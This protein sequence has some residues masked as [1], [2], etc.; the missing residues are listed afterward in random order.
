MAAVG[1]SRFGGV[2]VMTFFP[3]LLLW[4]RS[5]QGS[6]ILSPEESVRPAM[7]AGAGEDG[8]GGFV[9]PSLLEQ[10]S[11]LD[12]QN[13]L[14]SLRGQFLRTFNLS[15]L[16][17]P[18]QPG[19]TRVEPPE[20]MM[21]LYNRF[22]NDHTAMPSANIVRSF[23][24]EDTSP[25]SVG[26]EGV[27][28]HPLLFNVSIPRHERVT[29]AELRLY[30]L[31]Q[32][33][34]RIYTG[35]DRKVTVFEVRGERRAVEDK[36]RIR[37]EGE[38]EGGE[39]G[40]GAAE[41]V[42]LASR[43]VYGTDDGWE[44]FDLTAAVHHWRKSEYD[45]THRLEVH[46]ASLGAEA[47]TRRSVVG[48][49]AGGDRTI[50]GDMEI[51]VSPE[52]KH[53]PLMI[54]FSDDQSGD[55]RGDKR[56]INEMIGHES[57]G[58]GLHENLDLRLNGLWAGAGEEDEDEQDEE[59]LMQMRSNLIYDT[60]SRIRRN[61]KGNQCKKTS[62]YVE[63]KDIGWENWILAPTGYEAFECKGICTYPL[64]KHVTPTKHAIIQTLVSMKSPQRVARACCVATKLDPISLLYLDDTGVVTYKYKYEG[65]VVAEC[66]CR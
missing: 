19:A 58:T 59:A 20:Y 16:G 54:V 51:D 44:S 46:I 62:L 45:T 13:I 38:G 24:N 8:H 65:M 15:G 32:R 55:H 7:Q 42:E 52:A 48:D 25:Y 40:G 21:E 36:H 43:Q 9:D 31:V 29:A 14:D 6:P 1:V 33:D 41:P 3:L 10:D 66:G 39:E 18:L 5:G 37:R 26:A 17:P 53:K 35:V 22:A 47:G 4:P 49:E 27:R 50:E 12:M 2:Y 28:R 30:T 60:A 34:R 56:E 61:A 57:A 64:T 63:F 23:K 11:D